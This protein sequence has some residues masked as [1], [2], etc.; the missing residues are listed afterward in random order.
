MT[1]PAS[2][3]KWNRTDPTSDLRFLQLD[4]PVRS[5]AATSPKQPCAIALL[6]VGVYTSPSVGPPLQSLPSPSASSAFSHAPK[7]TGAAL[8]GHSRGLFPSDSTSRASVATIATD[9][10]SRYPLPPFYEIF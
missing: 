10:P 8:V 1:N 7:I 5:T 6:I 4:R 3:P 9:H 2:G